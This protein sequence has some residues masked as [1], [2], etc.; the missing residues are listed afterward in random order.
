MSVRK[1]NDIIAGKLAVDAALSTVSENPVQNKVVTTA[2]NSKANI[3]SLAIVATTGDYT[4]LLNKPTIPAAQVNSDWNA[5]SGV[6]QILNKPTLGTMAVENASDYTKT[7][8]LASVA[9]TG[10]YDDLLNKPTIPTVNDATL[11]IQKNG[12]NVATF[13]ANASSNVTANISVPTT[14]NDLT[15]NSGF[16]TSSDIPVTDVTVGGTS[17]V[18]SGV[19][20]VPAIPTVNNPTI[21]I[22]QG[23]VTKGSFTL[24]QASGDTIA[25]DAGGGGSSY[26]P[27]LF[28]VKWADHICNDVQWL[29]ADTYSWQSGAVYQVAYQH[30]EDD[31]D[32][33]TL[34]SETIAGITIQFYLAD[35]GHKICPASEES[36]VSAIYN[37]T[38]VDWYYIIDTANTRFKLPR[39]Q[40]AFTGIRS[41]V[42]AF[43]EAGLP[44]ITGSFSTASDKNLGTGAFSWTTTKYATNGG[45][46]GGQW[47]INFSAQN[48]NSIYGNSNTVQPKATEMYLYFYV[49]NFTQTAL[50]NT[51]GITTE[52]MNNKVNIGHEV[53]EFQE[54]TAANNYTWY[55]KYRDGWVE[56]GGLCSGTAESNSVSMPVEMSNT[57]YQVSAISDPTDSV[58]SWGWVVVVRNSKTT[59][60]FSLGCRYGSGSVVALRTHWQVSGIAA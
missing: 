25:L 48:S 7:S 13:T 29:R 56:Q 3:S 18:S 41:G 2:L 33:K 40:F 39:T 12:T 20:V 22:T 51:A 9:T 32:G 43:V 57:E 47:G 46:S 8:G 27:D 60:G 38:G 49:G 26:H 28:D 55:R 5:N 11:T 59:T 34:Q 37:A 44:N 54:P 21:T 23:G 30:L 35:D 53:I 58:N 52:E 10:D 16:I 19:A 45:G 6:E 14:T 4:D 42:G 1:G 17:V 36:N 50:E 15:N 24:N 31:I